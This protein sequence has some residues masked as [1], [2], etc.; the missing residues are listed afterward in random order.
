MYCCG[1]SESVSAAGISLHVDSHLSPGPRTHCVKLF[2]IGPVNPA[3]VHRIVCL[4]KVN[5]AAFFAQACSVWFASDAV[6]G[7]STGTRVPRS[8]RRLRLPRLGGA[9]YAVT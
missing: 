1:Q 9:A 7:S 2:T 3:K 5:M 8:G 6:D 4:I